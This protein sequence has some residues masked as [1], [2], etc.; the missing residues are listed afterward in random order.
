MNNFYIIVKVIKPMKFLVIGN[1]T[2]DLIKTGQNEKIAFGGSSSYSSITAKRLGCQSFVL[3]RGNEEFK[4]WIDFLEKEEIKVELQKSKK[5]TSFV[6]EYTEFGRTQKILSDAGKIEFKNLGEM[7]AIHIGPVFNEI[8]L[9]CVK[10]ARKNCKLLSLDVQGFVRK[11]VK[12]GVE[13]KFWKEREKFLKYVD[14][15]KVSADEITSVSDELNY[16]DVCKELVNL[17]VKVVELTF[18][19][20]GSIVFGEKLHKIPVYKTNVIDKTG[21]GDVYATAFAIRYFETKDELNS[22]LFASAAASFVVEDFGTNNIAEKDR[23]E[24]RYKEL[25]VIQ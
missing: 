18:G 6:N 3:S 11:S 17:G 15:L 2:K 14:L 16:E 25:K 4:D 5:I 19:E 1:L 12:G 20:K 8:T 22:G 23:V 10:K 24:E 9:E 7:D 21:S 13:K